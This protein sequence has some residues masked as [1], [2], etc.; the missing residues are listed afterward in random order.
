MRTCL[1][2]G[3]YASICTSRNLGEEA[4]LDGDGWRWVEM[5]GKY[6]VDVDRMHLAHLGR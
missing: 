6:H 5:G 2:C 1:R 4:V 3:D